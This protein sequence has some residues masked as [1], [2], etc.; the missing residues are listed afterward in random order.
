[1]EK[2]KY[3]FDSFIPPEEI[4]KMTD[5]EYY[6]YLMYNLRKSED[7]L[8]NGRYTDFNEYMDEFERK[9]NIGAD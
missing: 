1:M 9:Y 7:D 8:R 5:K 2:R 4:E 3:N 6:D